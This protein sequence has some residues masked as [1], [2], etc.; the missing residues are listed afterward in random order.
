MCTL[1]WTADGGTGLYVVAVQI[2]D[3]IS[4]TST[5][6]LSSVPLQFLINVFS[7]TEP[8]AGGTR[9]SLVAGETP[10]HNSI[11]TL[12]SDATYSAGLVADS[13]GTAER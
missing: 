5:V 8:C 4:C 9:P 6:A 11:V 3:F 2:E 7:S 10:P 13:G 12:Y 1:T